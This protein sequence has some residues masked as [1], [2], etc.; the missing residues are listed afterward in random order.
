MSQ[1]KERFE[2]ALAEFCAKQGHFVGGDNHIRWAYIEG[3]KRAKELCIN[4]IDAEQIEAV[5][6]ELSQ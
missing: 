2:K 4:P 3:L 1:E 5:I 6:K